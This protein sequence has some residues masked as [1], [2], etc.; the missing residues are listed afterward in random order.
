MKKI[1]L[2]KRLLLIKLQR[3]INQENFKDN[4]L[5]ILENSKINWD[6]IQYLDEVKIDILEDHTL[7]NDRIKN[8][9]KR[10]INLDE[11]EENIKQDPNKYKE[12]FEKEV[13]WY[14]ARLKKDIRLY[15]ETILYLDMYGRDIEDFFIISKHN[16]QDLKKSQ[17]F[18]N[19][20][21]DINERSLNVKIDNIIYFNNIQ[22]I[23]K[24]KESLREKEILYEQL[25]SPIEKSKILLDLF[26]NQLNLVR[27]KSLNIIIKLE[28]FNL[29]MNK[30]NDINF[31]VKKEKNRIVLKRINN[32][33]KR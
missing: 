10:Y 24:I 15:E 26:E 22:Y 2:F 31:I 27:E 29:S 28:K 20:F 8:L 11:F 5:N 21:I 33:K 14:N 12:A 3:L 32:N 13:I 17:E 30:E 25:L 18:F 23:N 9:E 16:I 7:F 4:L 19:R 6:N 1:Y